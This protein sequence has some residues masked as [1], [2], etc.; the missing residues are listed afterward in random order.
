MVRVSAEQTETRTIG[1][2]PHGHDCPAGNS[3]RE[4]PTGMESYR[5]VYGSWTRIISLED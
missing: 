4:L 5:A 2:D 1:H 3:P